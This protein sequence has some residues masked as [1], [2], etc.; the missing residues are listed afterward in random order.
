MDF[1][2]NNINLVLGSVVLTLIPI[3]SWAAKPVDD[4]EVQVVRTI[5]QHWQGDKRL[6]GRQC[7]DL[8]VKLAADGKVIALGQGT[9]DEAVCNAARTTISRMKR[10]PAPPKDKYEQYKNM[11]LTLQPGIR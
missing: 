6:H 8:S 9:G 1:N 11:L 7:V 10:L 2:M 4:Y 3:V 5:Q